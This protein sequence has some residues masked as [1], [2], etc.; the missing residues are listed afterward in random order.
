MLHTF[1]VFENFGFRFVH[2]LSP[3]DICNQPDSDRQEKPLPSLRVILQCLARSPTT[4]TTFYPSNNLPQ[5]LTNIAHNTRFQSPALR[6]RVALDLLQMVFARHCLGN[7]SEYV[8][9]RCGG[10]HILNRDWEVR[11]ATDTNHQYLMQ[12]SSHFCHRVGALWEETRR[13]NSL[14]SRN[15]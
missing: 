9:Q 7:V 3:I 12:H 10:L 13:A 8:V 6:S 1:K 14:G 2:K 11:R 15:I 4:S 5:T